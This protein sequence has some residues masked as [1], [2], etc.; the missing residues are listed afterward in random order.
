MPFPFFVMRKQLLPELEKCRI[1]TGMGLY[2]SSSKDGYCG[3]FKIPLSRNRTAMVVSADGEGWDHVSVHVEH[4][5]P[6]MNKYE[7]CT[8]T[9]DE[10]CKIKS[11]F[12]DKDEWVMQLHPP[13]SKNISIHDNCL[14]LWRPQNKEIPLPP[15]YLV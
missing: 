9:W 11:M 13:K 5:R 10:M 6:K 12:F 4:Y 8:P 7:S 3:C 1:V 2:N 15:R 14:H